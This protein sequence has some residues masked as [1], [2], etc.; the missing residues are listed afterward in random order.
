MLIICPTPIGNLEDVTARQRSALEGADIIACEDSR[1]TGKLLSLLGI[2]RADG[3]PRLVPYH[4]HNEREAVDEL[5]GE[6][7]RGRRVVLV[8]DA[9]TPAISDPGYRLVRRAVDAGVEITALPGPVAA[10]VALSASG[11]PTDA[12]QFYGFLPTSAEARRSAL[13]DADRAGVTSIFYESPKR[14][15]ALLSDVASVCGD[16]RPVCVGRE[17]TKM[18]EEYVR[19]AAQEVRREFAGRDAVRGEC[20]LV[21]GPAPEETEEAGDAEVDALIEAMLEAGC[22]SRTIKD[23]VSQVHDVARSEMYDRI[24]AVDEQRDD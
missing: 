23:V 16:D 12:W 4:E 17:L 1:R 15:E 22:R 3:S 24:D 13:E 14:M 5:V 18:H 2:E 20:V 21:V 9:G 19:G 8:S 6:L 7:T 11:L 10:M